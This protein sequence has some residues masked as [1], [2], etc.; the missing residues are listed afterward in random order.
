MT[1]RRFLAGLAAAGIPFAAR[2]VTGQPLAPP[3]PPPLGPPPPPPLPPPVPPPPVSAEPAAFA[4]GPASFDV[5]TNSA[6]VWLR[7]HGETEVRVEYGTL[8]L[9]GQAT[10]TTA[11]TASV[12]NDSIVVTELDRLPK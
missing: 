1:R 5:T 11:A 7:P 8:P 4:F 10:L 6:L 9:L 12:Q 3:P 2:P